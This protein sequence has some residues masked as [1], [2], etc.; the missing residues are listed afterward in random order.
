MLFI[1]SFFILLI[2]HSHNQF[3]K[4]IYPISF[5][6][7]FL[8]SFFL[9]LIL[10][11][12]SFNNHYFIYN[13]LSF[14]KFIISIS[15][16]I[17]FFILLSFHALSFLI[18]QPAVFILICLYSCVY[19]C[20]YLCFCGYISIYLCSSVSIFLKIYPCF[21]VY[22]S[23]FI[24]MLLCLYLSLLLGLYLY[25]QITAEHTK[26]LVESAGW[27]SKE[28]SL[29]KEFLLICVAIE[30]YVVILSVPQLRLS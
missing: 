15:F 2:F 27:V 25:L 26:G 12:L 14:F 4:F 3:F 24:Y 6:I 21:C 9:A 17:S 10:L 1:F 19:I 23:I 28:L 7:S 22:L 20:K 11:T 13:P 18:I 16:I 8:K 5:I 30:Y 29:I